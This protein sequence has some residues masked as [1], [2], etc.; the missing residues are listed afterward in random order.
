MD[1]DADLRID[2]GSLDVEWLDQ[3]RRFAKYA[4]LSAEANMQADLAKEQRELVEAELDN[5][6][7]QNPEAFGIAKVTEPAIEKAIK[8]QRQY[9]R[10]SLK[11]IKA[12]FEAAV[13][14]GAVRSFDHR[15]TALEHYQRLW[16]REY[17]SLPRPLPVQDDDWR[18]RVQ[19][20]EERQASEVEN[21]IAE[22]M[23]FERLHQRR[24]SDDDEQ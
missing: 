6:I 11:A 22:R 1:Y 15:K 7:R 16:E 5:R 20:T 18:E 13:L 10:A 17:V 14:A 3:P 21:A 9:K 4:H 19:K 2:P 12:K 23:R 8:Q 24:K